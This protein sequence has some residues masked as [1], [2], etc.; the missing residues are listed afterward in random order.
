[1]TGTSALGLT[2][3]LTRTFAATPAQVWAAWTDPAVLPRWFG[4][5]GFGCRTH[6]IDIREGGQWRFDMVGAMG[7]KVMTFPNRHRY[8]RLVPTAR[9]DFLMDDDS[10]D[11]APYEVTVTLTAE[12][13]GTRL[14]QVM[15]FPDAASL[16][17]AREM[18]AEAL[19]M[20]TLAKLAAIV[21]V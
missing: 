9:I 3:T 4:P 18:G 14:T 15:T 2:M 7:G 1:M 6:E 19:G 20:T 11:A 17:A 8:L 21:E 5:E 12:G 10:D 16:Q 13:S